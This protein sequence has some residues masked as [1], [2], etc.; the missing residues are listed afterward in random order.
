MGFFQH[1]HS[2]PQASPVKS[3]IADSGR[4]AWKQG[5]LD[6]LTRACSILHALPMLKF[7]L[8]IRARSNSARVLV[9]SQAQE[10]AATGRQAAENVILA[11]TRRRRSG[12]V[13]ARG[14]CVLTRNPKGAPAASLL[15][16]T[17]PGPG[18]RHAYE[19]AAQAPRTQ[20]VLA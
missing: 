16:P 4:R 13:I 15:R 5:R 17:Q 9:C 10:L 6:S 18:R 3:S 1:T 2:S 11:L 7:I 12:C 20:T 19:T 8:T 14:A